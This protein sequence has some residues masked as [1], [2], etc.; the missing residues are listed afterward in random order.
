M[1]GINLNRNRGLRRQLTLRSLALCSQPADRALIP[2]WV[3]VELSTKLADAVAQHPVVKIF[4]SKVGVACSRLHLED[5]SLNRKDRHVKGATTH[6]KHEDGHLPSFLLLGV[7][8]VRNCGGC[9]LVHNTGYAQTS[10]LSRILCCL[11]LRIVEVR[12]HSDDSFPDPSPKI[13]L[14]R[15]FHLEKH[16]RRDFLRMELLG[17]P[18]EHNLDQGLVV[19]GPIGNNSEGPQLEIRLHNRVLE[20]PPYQPLCIKN[21]ICRVAGDLV[22]RSI[23]DKSFLFCPRNV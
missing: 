11:T 5:L 10:N 18:L 3:R 21:R 15:L 16:H 6:V 4:S 1:Q 9:G 2:S 8:A 14:S 20:L 7:Q 17:D 19:T 13:R 12:G 23:S 22:L